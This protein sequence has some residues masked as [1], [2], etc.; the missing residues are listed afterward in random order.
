MIWE[1]TA[2][3]T[4]ALDRNFGAGSGQLIQAYDV[5]FG[6]DIARAATALT[7][8]DLLLAKF[9]KPA[10]I[11]DRLWQQYLN[12]AVGMA[13]LLVYDFNTR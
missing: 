12:A 11:S 9:D 7:S 13:R 10:D 2:N 3:F 4:A 8:T 5:Q 1:Y 6:N